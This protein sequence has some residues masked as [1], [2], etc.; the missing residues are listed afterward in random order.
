MNKELDK[1][2]ELGIVEPSKSDWSSP[3]PLLDKPDG[4]KRFCV[5]LRKVNQVSKKG[6]S[7]LPMVA[8]ILDRLRRARYLSSLDIKSAYCQIPLEES[9]KE[10]TAFTIAGRGLF[11]FTTMPFGLSN[12]L[13]TW[14]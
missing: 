1:I 7:S 11:Q 10:K 2:L 14:Q 8:T 5:D 9:S 3:I 6:A 4:S 12:A 13:I